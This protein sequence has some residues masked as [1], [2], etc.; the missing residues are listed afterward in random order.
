[1][2]MTARSESLKL[3]R[4]GSCEMDRAEH[5]CLRRQG[6]SIFGEGSQLLFK[7]GLFLTGILLQ[8][9]VRAKQCGCAPTPA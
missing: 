2:Q 5:S 3:C 4:G 9:A 6:M 7:P 8:H 1:M